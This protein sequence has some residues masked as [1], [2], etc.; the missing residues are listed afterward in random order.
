M[1]ALFSLTILICLV[2]AASPATAQSLLTVS[3][4]GW[5][6]TVDQ[7]HQAITVSHETLGPVLANVRLN[8]RAEQ[9]LIPLADW[10]A[11]KKA[12]NLLAFRTA[13]PP[14][15]WL[16]EL[17]PDALKISCSSA[18]AVLT[19]DAP[20]SANRIPVRLLDSQG[21]P[22]DWVGTWE[23][24]EGYGGPETRNRSFL[25]RQNPEVMYFA[26]GP[27]SSSNLHSLFDRR[28]T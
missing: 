25:P 1:R 16:I 5:A 27:V 20:A 7:E 15:R 28:T 17:D 10:S 9:G 11:Q 19:G 12:P 6:L 24:H 4:A 21:F 18:R 13:N 23:V 14:T 2:A 26:L 3:N 8:L 22:V